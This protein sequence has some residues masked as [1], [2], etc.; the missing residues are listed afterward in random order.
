MG[1]SIGVWVGLGLLGGFVGKGVVGFGL[2]LRYLNTQADGKSSSFELPT[3]SSRPDSD[4]STFAYGS[5]AINIGE[6][7]SVHFFDF[8]ESVNIVTR[9]PIGRLF[10]SSQAVPP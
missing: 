5:S 1:T 9:L 10:G 3:I 8:D 2:A 7:S 4:R 6:P